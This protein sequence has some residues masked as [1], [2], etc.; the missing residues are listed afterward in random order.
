M[1]HI[2]KWAFI[3]GLGLA[4]VAAFVDLWWLPWLVGGLG[5]VVGYLN[6]A[7]TEVKSFLLAGL[8]LTVALMA[9][10]AQHYNPQWLTDIMFYEKVFVSHAL[11]LVALIAVFKVAK[12]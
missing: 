7:E 10:Q 3:A 1:K 12:E 6:V 9:I 11:L 2:G 4:V 5:L 8:G